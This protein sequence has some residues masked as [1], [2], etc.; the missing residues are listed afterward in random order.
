MR[1][2]RRNHRSSP[3]PD[4][5][6]ASGDGLVPLIGRFFP[7]PLAAKVP[8]VIFVFWVV[9][10]L[11]TA[12]GEATSDY[13]KTFGNIEGGGIEVLVIVVGLALQFE[14]RRYRAFAYWFLA[15]AIAITGTGVADF[16]HL[17]VHIPYSG[18]TLLWA[19][20]L[21]AIFWLWQRSEGTLSIHSI[22]TQRRE[23][24]YWATVFATFALGTAL[25]DY[26]AVSLNLG[27]LD[28]GIL[29][30]V[31]ILIP[32][33]ARWQLGL[34][35]IAAFWMS[36]VITRPLGASF[37]DYISKSHNLSGINF[38]DGPTAIVFAVAVLILVS[39]LARAR[40]DIQQPLE[41]PAAQTRS[42]PLLPDLL[43]TGELEIESD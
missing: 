19:A 13:L 39:Y 15:Y 28:S 23:A 35:G 12:G 7:A 43:H 42:T 2:V 6:A 24:F 4:P 37:A 36:Y 31:V 33:V 9:K 16:L 34:N 38:G 3:S 5:V 20:I 32:A 26:T 21:A 40:P 41:A 25:G 10:I 1:S 14:A 11:T 29:F 27:Y 18:T 8:E 17:D 30:G 22:T